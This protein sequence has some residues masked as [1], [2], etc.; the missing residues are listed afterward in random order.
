MA[1]ILHLASP[2]DWEK[3]KKRGEYRS[4]SLDTEG[5][6]HCATPQ[7]LP[8]VA[9]RLFPDQEG[10]LVLVINEDNVIPE[11]RYE[12]PEGSAQKFPHIYGP[13]NLQAVVRTAVLRRGKNGEM[14]L[15][16]YLA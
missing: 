8:Q 1:I 12:A 11:I 16:D 2:E 10:L 14:E 15:D 7:Q 6:I 5:F 13:L 3:A 9:D 4:L